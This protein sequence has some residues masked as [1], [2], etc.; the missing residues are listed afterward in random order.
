MISQAER[1]GSK[2][3]ARISTSDS[4]FDTFRIDN[5]HAALRQSAAMDRL[6]SAIEQSLQSLPALSRVT[7]LVWWHDLKK[8]E[9][10]RRSSSNIG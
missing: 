1:R 7:T 4:S 3:Q 6:I 10:Q 8:P 2:V 5:F 9:L